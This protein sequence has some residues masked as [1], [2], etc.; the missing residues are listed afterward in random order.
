MI[1]IQGKLNSISIESI[2][3]RLRDI[4]HIVRANP[5]PTM[6]DFE[7]KQVWPK[8]PTILHEDPVILPTI[9]HLPKTQLRRSGHCLDIGP[10][11]CK[12]EWKE[13]LDKDMARS[14]SNLN[15]CTLLTATPYVQS[16][17]DGDQH[18]ISMAN[19]VAKFKLI[20]Y[21]AL[22]DVIVPK[23]N[24]PLK[25]NIRTTQRSSARAYNEKRGEPDFG[26][27]ASNSG[28][29]DASPSVVSELTQLFAAKNQPKT[30]VVVEKSTT[31]I[32]LARSLTMHAALKASRTT[33]MCLAGPRLLMLD[34][35]NNGVYRFRGSADSMNKFSGRY[36]K[37]VQDRE[38]QFQ[39]YVGVRRQ[40]EGA[41][42]RAQRECHLRGVHDALCDR[43]WL[44]WCEDDHKQPNQGRRKDYA[45]RGTSHASVWIQRCRY[46]K[47]TSFPY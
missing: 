46:R 43:L 10:S 15:S 24:H 38:S 27:I 17:Y 3:T 31:A 37:G 5:L 8:T 13:M 7:P 12:Y 2:L 34:D 26:M 9:C 29:W 45:A 4:R 41:I 44:L 33:I 35:Q 21:C 20:Y 25:L 23:L 19:F 36:R 42:Q 16:R 14:D 47:W 40:S 1:Q 11:S 22:D 39:G 18:P 30:L 28:I 32:R 6:E